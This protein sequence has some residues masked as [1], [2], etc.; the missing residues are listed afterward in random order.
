MRPL[1]SPG[2]AL[3]LRV[4][5]L[6]FALLA[7]SP[8]AAQQ[9]GAVELLVRESG[10]GRPLPDAAARLVSTGQFALTDPTGHALILEVPAGRHT[11]ELRHPGHALQTVEVEVDAREVTQLQ[12]AL[13]VQ[14]IELEGVEVTAE[15]RVARL[16]RSGFYH[17]QKVYWGNFL[18]PGDL[19][20]ARRQGT[21]LSNLLRGRSG[22]SILPTGSGG[23]TVVSSRSV[24]TQ[25]CQTAIYVDGVRQYRVDNL[26]RLI[27]MVDIEAIE[28][29]AGRFSTPIEFQ[30]G[31]YCGAVVIWTPG[32]R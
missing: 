7:A 19:V 31:G 8:L 15:A 26:D 28:I 17:R 13:Q 20:T 22:L 6:L 14:P 18:G 4:A 27:S 23:Y 9:T 24:A 29:Y 12:V 10:S 3:P 21:P 25:P 2:A 1:A 5:L 11:V 16:E 32:G 30:G